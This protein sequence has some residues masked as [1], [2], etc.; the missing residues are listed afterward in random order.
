M[1]KLT[2]TEMNA[3]IE[4]QYAYV[5]KLTAEYQAANAAGLYR[6]LPTMMHSILANERDLAE[7]V[8]SA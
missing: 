6:D 5:A 2:K 4:A 7:M 1:K 3:A 8:R